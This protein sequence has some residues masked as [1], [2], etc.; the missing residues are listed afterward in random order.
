MRRLLCIVTM[1]AA[2]VMAA[3]SPVSAT[4]PSEVVIT[5][6]LD[7]DFGATTSFDAT[8]GIVCATGVVDSEFVRGAGDQSGQGVNLTVLKHFTCDD[9]TFVLKLQIRL[10]FDG[11]GTTFNWVVKG[12]TGAYE[13]LRGSERGAGVGSDDGS[14]V[15]DT[16][17]GGLHVH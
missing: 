7:D 3:L 6:V 4:P 5:N 17:T 14:T 12:G 11:T 9:G 1:T 16:Y 13:K 8:G 15:T 2:L 10:R